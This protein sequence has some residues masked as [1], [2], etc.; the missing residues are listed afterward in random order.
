MARK[1]IP[2]GHRGMIQKMDE[3]YKDILASSIKQQATSNKQ[4]ATRNMEITRRLGNIAAWMSVILEGI[5]VCLPL[6]LVSAPDWMT[7]EINLFYIRFYKR[8]SKPV[9]DI[10]LANWA[11][12]KDCLLLTYI[13]CVTF[14]GLLGRVNPS[15]YCHTMPY[16]AH[17]EN[18][19]GNT[20]S[21]CCSSCYDNPNSVLQLTPCGH[22]F[23]RECVAEWVLRKKTCPNCRCKV[24]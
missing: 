4:Q 19:K 12:V 10:R 18:A 2:K 17:N 1:K 21:I 20:C 16:E 15:S 6:A 3:V 23:H 24:L 14:C 7:S 9:C 11:L 8:Q 13:G 5:F 22:C